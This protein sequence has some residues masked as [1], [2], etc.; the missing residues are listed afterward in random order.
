M[1]RDQVDHTMRALLKAIIDFEAQK[2]IHST[3]EFD[4][5]EF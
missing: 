4:R 1:I 3:P 5:T 2:N